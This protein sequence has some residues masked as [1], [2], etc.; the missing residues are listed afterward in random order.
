M[1][2]RN[3]LQ[4][5]MAP[6]TTASHVC[7]SEI[8]SQIFRKVPTRDVIYTEQHEPKRNAHNDNNAI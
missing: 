6:Q 7:G 8:C 5:V 1:C 3:W 4:L 2:M